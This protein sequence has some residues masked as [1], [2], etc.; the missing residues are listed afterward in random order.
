MDIDNI[1]LS[2]MI[3]SGEKKYIYFIDYLDGDYKIKP[4]HIMLLKTTP[5]VKGYNGQMECMYF[6]IE[7]DD[8]LKRYNNFDEKR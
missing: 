4:S 8:L 5:C 6:L 1:L 2:N 7:D 3:P